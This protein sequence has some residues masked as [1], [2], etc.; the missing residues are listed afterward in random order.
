MVAGNSKSQPQQQRQF[1][2][3]LLL[4]QRA[5]T[6]R[7]LPAAMAPWGLTADPFPTRDGVILLKS[8]SKRGESLEVEVG[9]MTMMQPWVSIAY[10]W[11]PMIGDVSNLL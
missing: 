9:S 7:R 8:L 1:V 10:V 2:V 3:P 4:S 6:D 5:R 11:L